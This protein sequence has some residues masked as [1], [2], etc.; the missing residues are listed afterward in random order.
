MTKCLVNSLTRLKSNRFC[1]VLNKHCYPIS[2]TLY[3]VRTQRHMLFSKCFSHKQIH[4]SHGARWAINEP[5]FCVYTHNSKGASSHTTIYALRMY[6][7]EHTYEHIWYICLIWKMRVCVVAMVVV[8][9]IVEIGGKFLVWCVCVCV[10]R[11]GK[12]HTCHAYTHFFHVNVSQFCHRFAIVC[13]TNHKYHYDGDTWNVQHTHATKTSPCP[14]QRAACV[15]SAHNIT[16]ITRTKNK[17]SGCKCRVQR[18][19]GGSK[20]TK[21]DVH[22]VKVG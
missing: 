10:R 21:S 19:G 22:I 20:T 9:S 4:K 15:C 2:A 5:K 16:L 7:H 6:M 1:V 17:W 14:T 3:T 13:N 18:V 8:S 11:K 12:A